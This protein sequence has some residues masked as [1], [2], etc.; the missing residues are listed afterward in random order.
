[1]I[2]SRILQ[3]RLRSLKYHN[4]ASGC[5]GKIDKIHHDIF[6]YNTSVKL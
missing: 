6:Y 4:G 2:F 3:A 1:M 5:S